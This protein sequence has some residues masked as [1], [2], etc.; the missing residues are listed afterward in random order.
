MIVSAFFRSH[1]TWAIAMQGWQCRPALTF[2]DP[3]DLSQLSTWPDCVVHAFLWSNS[4]SRPFGVNDCSTTICTFDPL[5]DRSKRCG[6]DQLPQQTKRT[7]S[8]KRRIACLSA[9]GMHTV[10]LVYFRKRTRSM[11]SRQR[12]FLSIGAFLERIATDLSDFK[13]TLLCARGRPTKNPNLILI[14]FPLILMTNK[15]VRSCA[16]YA[17]L[18]VVLAENLELEEPSFNSNKLKK[19]KHDYYGAYSHSFSSISAF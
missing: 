5:V 13:S 2:H 6:Q 19:K 15:K 3:K 12:A 14:L 18:G 16:H 7:H 1:D 8:I 4:C 11:S 10:L 9:E 17:C